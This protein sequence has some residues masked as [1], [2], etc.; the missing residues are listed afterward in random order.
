MEGGVVHWGGRR[1]E[2]GGKYLL[3]GPVGGVQNGLVRHIVG[4]GA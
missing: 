4:A 1:G 3:W 2:R